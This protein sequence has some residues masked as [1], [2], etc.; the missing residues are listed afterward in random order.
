MTADGLGGVWTYAIELVREF[1]RRGIEVAM[2][3]MGSPLQ[4]DQAR[5]ASRIN[6]LEV[7]ES[8]L[9]LEWMPDP[10]QE[11]DDAGDW[12]LYLEQLVE[13]DIVHLNGYV[14]GVLPWNSPTVMVA[15]S[16]VS[17]WWQAVK[18]ESVPPQWNT[19]VER[20]TRGLASADHV[21]AP[22][23]SMLRSVEENYGRLSSTSVIHNG[24]AA[25]GFR[26]GPKDDLVF[27]AGRLWDEAKNIAALDR[28]AAGLPWPVFIAGDRSADA[29]DDR[30]SLAL[31]NSRLL[32][33]LSLKE[34]SDWYSRAS[35]Y[36]LPAKYEPFGLTALEAGISGCALV[37]GDIP[38]LREVWDDAALF[39]SPH[40]DDELR[41]TI[42]Q[43]IENAGLRQEMA[44]RARTRASRFTP[45][46]MSDA[47]I[48]LYAGLLQYR[49]AEITQVQENIA[50]V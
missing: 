12:L 31:N 43:L 33:R 26:S 46:K 40:D 28:I 8:D 6:N 32:G 22:T 16:C 14:H 25:E 21:V 41:D 5:Q 9:K 4:L 18:D 36:V 15:H 37:L 20:V 50:C 49:S 38:S 24:R 48:E 23:F 42:V 11:V 34:L 30:S 17:S 27:S 47:Y 39:V 10:W 13:P 1:G 45:Q 3:T 7:F 19:Y 35:V 44:D 2:A 29:V